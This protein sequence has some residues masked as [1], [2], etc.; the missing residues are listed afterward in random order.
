MR[1]HERV[2]EHLGVRRRRP[3]DDR[4]AVVAH[5]LISATPPTSTSVDG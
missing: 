3:D 1:L 4:V 5:P 2:A